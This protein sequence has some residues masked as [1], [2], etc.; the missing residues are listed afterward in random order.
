MSLMNDMLRDLS[1]RQA[2]SPAYAGDENRLRDWEQ[3]K[4]SHFFDKFSHWPVVLLSVFL[5]ISV[6]GIMRWISSEEISYPDIIP[7]QVKLSV[8]LPSNPEP[9]DRSIDKL[10]VEKRHLDQITLD[11]IAVN[12]K[13]LDKIPLPTSLDPEFTQTE[14][15]I[16]QGQ[17]VSPELKMTDEL[18]NNFPNKIQSVSNYQQ[19]SIYELID[20][21]SRALALDRLTSPENDNAWF[22]YQSLLKLDTQN[23]IALDGMV[24]ITQRYLQM[25]EIAINK[26]QF[27]K[28]VLYLEKAK[29]VSADIRL[30]A[31]Y[32][33]SLE[34]FT[35]Q[36]TAPHSSDINPVID[37]FISNEGPLES[38]DSSAVS[39]ES[40][41][42]SVE[43]PLAQ[44]Q[45]VVRLPNQEYKDEQ[46]VDNAKNLV[47]NGQ[48]SQAIEI[49]QLQI[50]EASSPLSEA[51]LLEIYYQQ[52][53]LS[54]M[55]SFLQN[56]SLSEPGKAYYQARLLMLQNDDPAAIAQLESHLA[57]AK[58]NENFRAL[59][60][61]LYQREG[62]SLQA[63]TA[64]RN[65]LQ[66]FQPQPAYWLGLA[67]SLDTEHQSQ[68]AIFAYQKLLEFDSVEARVIEYA[69][70]RI[71]ELSQ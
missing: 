56:T 23:S 13:V 41:S 70:N 26:Q 35:Q 31:I 19:Q 12:Q 61:G 10:S 53:N 43:N 62:Q 39:T 3:E 27:E 34:N 58:Q 49:L 4:I 21:A 11:Q 71:T 67:L 8:K 22:Y 50:Q 45:S 2:A 69:K 5:F 28:A 9:I 17:S 38:V 15:N 18:S 64:Y 51:Y 44:V 25:I 7:A 46:S 54:A 32:A 14:G 1:E 52:K 65:L 59:L 20:K 40:N 47:A 37:T 57:N 24:R 68:S 33:Q 42:I 48:E 60:A 36:L 30:P 66:D 29:M 63:I 55:Q 16:S 6:V